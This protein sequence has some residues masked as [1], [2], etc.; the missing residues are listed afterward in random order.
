MSI[1]I[2]TRKIDKNDSRSSF[3]I[4]WILEFAKHIDNLYIICQE[5]GDSG[6]L[7]DNVEIYSLEK[8]KGKNRISQFTLLLYYF[9]TLL[10]K[11]DGVFSHMMPIYSVVAGPWCKIYHKKLIQWY[12]HKKVNLMLKIANFWVDEFISASP[13]SFHLKTK[14]K[15]NIFGHGINTENFQFPISNFQKN[16][17]IQNSKFKILSVGR[18]SPVKNIDLI[19]KTAEIIKLSNLEFKDKILF[20]IIGGPGLLEQASYMKDLEKEVHE[21]KLDS[22]VDFLG[23]LP[24]DEIIPYYQNCDL[25]VNFSETGS[26]DKVVL[27]AMAS[28]KIVLTSNV[29]FKNIVPAEL[30]LE[31]NDTNL[32]IEK[33]KEIYF[34]QDDRKNK[35]RER[36]FKEVEE[37]HNLA[38]LIKKIV[39]LYR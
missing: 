2:I 5:L 17:K 16:S 35:I 27:E 21:K 23:P 36:L 31:K 11:T 6:A 7:P 4:D 15:V 14:K 34:M 28:K 39:A 13:E 24:Q 20:Q 32:L 9:I 25:F 10:P 3:F 37:N 19:V 18:I 33:I 22:V 30:F 1:L 26:L 12:T 38:N 29:A 8:E